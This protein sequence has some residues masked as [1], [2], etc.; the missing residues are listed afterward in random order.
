M[1]PTEVCGF[2]RF[3][4]IDWHA[5]SLDDKPLNLILKNGCSAYYWVDPKRY[6]V[7]KYYH[8]AA[9]IT[10]TEDSGF[11]LPFKGLDERLTLLRLTPAVIEDLR[12]MDRADVGDFTAGGL[13]HSD[14]PNGLPGELS[15]VQFDTCQL[16]D[17][18]QWRDVV[19]RENYWVKAWDLPKQTAHVRVE[20]IYLA[21]CDVD[22]ITARSI[23]VARMDTSVIG[24][25][26]P[27][28][29]EATEPEPKWESYPLLE[30]GQ[31]LPDRLLWIYR[32]A[33]KIKAAQSAEG[34]DGAAGSELSRPSWGS[35]DIKTWLRGVPPGG[36]FKSRLGPAAINLL[37]PDY[38]LAE[39][40]DV[41]VLSQ[42]PKAAE[43]GAM[44]LFTLP[45]QAA[46]AAY[47]FWSE[48]DAPAS[49]GGLLSLAMKLEQLGFERTRAMQVW[50]IIT[51]AREAR[52][53]R[54]A[55]QIDAIAAKSHLDALKAK[56]RIGV[57]HLDQ[58]D[59]DAESES[60]PE[61][62]PGGSSASPFGLVLKTAQRAQ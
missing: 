33:L 26:D 54:L 52:Y 36:M 32:G 7:L 14:A 2:V 43:L 11:D 25:P 39:G 9:R 1:T 49:A 5:L 48:L 34:H 15:E 42:L 62:Q 59:P 60:A 37:N 58:H 46:L 19:A 31:T 12:L 27:N 45:L 21:Q 55:I 61:K 10:D 40:F 8:R 47:H 16:I 13:A 17:R 56:E 3:A 51:G 18:A 28:G 41:E 44:G 6:A 23:R 53:K 20:N 35:E 4:S 24:S 38:K 22:A 30:E 57:A 29:C 50:M